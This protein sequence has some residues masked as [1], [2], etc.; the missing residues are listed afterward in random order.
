MHQRHGMPYMEA[1][2][3]EWGIEEVVLC[4]SFNKTGYLMSP[5]VEE[6]VEATKNNDASIYQLMAMSTLALSAIS[7]KEA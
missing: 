4:S 1:K 6:Y 7:A 2:L 5:G 3:E